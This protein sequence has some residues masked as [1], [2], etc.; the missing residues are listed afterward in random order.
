MYKI[1]NIGIDIIEIE[2][3]QDLLKRKP[4]FIEKFFSEEEI[5]P[6]RKKVNFERHLAARFAAKEA[7]VKALGTGFDGIPFKDIVVVKDTKGKPGIE[8]RGK[9]LKVAESR[10]ISGIALSLSFTHS[11]AAASAVALTTE[12]NTGL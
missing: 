11:T 6:I 1:S 12:E 4:R 3:I 5:A 7:A 8:L 2:R 10:G 9:A